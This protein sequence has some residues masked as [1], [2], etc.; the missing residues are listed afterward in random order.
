MDPRLTGALR[1][2]D[3]VRNA[4]TRHKL[5]PTLALSVLAKESEGDP[6]AVS[7]AG[8]LGLFQ[9]MPGTAASLGVDPRDPQ[10][11]IEGGV[12][13]L[14][15]QLKRYDGNLGK[16]LAA[17]NAG[18]G[19]VDKY[20]GIPPFPETQDYV[21]DVLGLR[22][23]L[24]TATTPPKNGFP[25]ILPSTPEPEKGNFFGIKWPEIF[26]A[27]FWK[28]AAVWLVLLVV[29]V[30]ALYVAFQSLARGERA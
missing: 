18:P 22:E 6:M 3:A 1:W 23:S 16:A 19:A 20:N 24:H 25:P 26:T 30:G 21:T 4:S 2:E 10:Q 9:L 17:Y 8:A 15:E 14:S 7:K 12:R 27:Q 11:N 28:L 29:G 5:D 13:Y